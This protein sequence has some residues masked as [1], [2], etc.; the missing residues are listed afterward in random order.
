MTTTTE[1]QVKMNKNT[2]DFIN[3]NKT[4]T[5]LTYGSDVSAK[6]MECFLNGQKFRY[7]DTSS[8]SNVI[9]VI[10]KVDEDTGNVTLISSGL[11]PDTLGFNM[12]KA[13]QLESKNKT[14]MRLQK[15]L[16]EK[17]SK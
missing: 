16:M 5:D 1:Q 8:G 4:N 9:P 15:K 14:I 17:R 13:S 12:M 6:D 11:P 3:Y 7:K 10:M 2:T